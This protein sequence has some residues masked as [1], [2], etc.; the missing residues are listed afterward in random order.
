MELDFEI[1]VDSPEPA[2][3]MKAGLDTLQGISDAAR[4]ITISFANDELAKRL[5]Y[6][7]G[8]RTKLKQS[9]RG[10]FGQ[11]FS[12]EVLGNHEQGRINEIGKSTFVELLAHTLTAAKYGKPRKLSLEARAILDEMQMSENDLVEEIRTSCMRRVH[13]LSAKF[14]H[15]VTVSYKPRNEDRLEVGKFTKKSALMLNTVFDPARIK[16]SAAVSRLN[17]NT[18]NGRLRL[19]GEKETVAF[20]FFGDYF[21]VDMDLKKIFSE[22][23]DENNGVRSDHWEHISL[24]A[25]TI[26]LKSGKIVKYLISGVA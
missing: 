13:K 1:I 22:N 3:D 8:I 20:G 21:F 9:F 24:Y 19:K 14:G 23:L 26:R 16:I 10:S 11:R 18:G 17:I 15:D 7:G 25:Q 12:I 6:Q 5:S 2:V 4:K